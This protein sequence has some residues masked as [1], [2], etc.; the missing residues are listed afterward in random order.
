MFCR[1]LIYQCHFTIYDCNH[2]LHRRNAHRAPWL[3]K[4]GS[5]SMREILVLVKTSSS[6]R[7]TFDVSQANTRNVSLREPLFLSESCSSWNKRFLA[8]ICMASVLHLTLCLSTQR[9]NELSIFLICLTTRKEDWRKAERKRRKKVNRG[10][11]IGITMLEQVAGFQRL[12]IRLEE[13]L[14]LY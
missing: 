5:P 9:S 6:V 3:T 10:R 1:L 13:S 4:Y 12:E 14:L 8:E 7:L 2:G 11:I